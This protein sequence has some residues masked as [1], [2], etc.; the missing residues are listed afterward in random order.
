[1]LLT[2]RTSPRS[3]L[4]P[5]TSSAPSVA[6]RTFERQVNGVTLFERR[7]GAGTPTVILHGGPGASH[8]YL[9]PGCDALADGRELIYYD[10]RGGGRSPVGRDVAVGWQ[11]HV[12]D[13]HTL[14]ELWGD[15]PLNLVGYSWGGLLAMLY[16]I[17]H[18]CSVAKLALVSP[19]PALGAGRATEAPRVRPQAA[20]R[21]RLPA[22]H[23]RARGDRL[24][25]GSGA[26]LRAPGLPA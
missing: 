17:K 26:G 1:M 14:K 10:Q 3:T 23:L 22:S 20:R 16:A 25:Q 8:D 11:E 2:W 9:L 13:L 7:T 15:Q 6:E 24:L 18:P 4:P 21:R 12:A 19:A 5:S